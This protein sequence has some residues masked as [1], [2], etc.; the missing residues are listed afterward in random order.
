MNI[1]ERLWQ[2]IALVAGVFAFVICILLIVTYLQIKKADPINMKVISTLVERLNQNP[3]DIELRNEVR[4]LDLLSRKAYFTNQWQIR[5]GGYMLLI[6]IAIMVIALQ[7]VSLN[8]KK[9]I[10]LLTNNNGSSDLYQKTTQKWVII[11]G[12]AIIAVALFFAFLSHNELKNKFSD[13]SI[14]KTEKLDN[15]LNNIVTDTT[16]ITNSQSDT[17]VSKIDK[18]NTDSAIATKVVESTDNF[19]T[20]RG[21]GGYG[22]ANQRN[23]PTKWNGKTGDNIL[24][25]IAVPLAGFN[26]PVTWGDK[27]FI[28][29]ANTSKR[30]VYCIDKNSG[31]YLWTTVVEKV[32][33]ASAKIPKVIAET[34]FA[35]PTAATNGKAVFAIFANGDIAAIDMNGKLLWSKNLGDPQN[36]YGYSSSLMIYNDLVIVQYDQRNAPKLLALSASTGNVVWSTSRK[37]KISWASPIVVNTGKRTEIIVV[38]EPY[39]ASYNPANGEE[40]WKIDCISGEVGPS[41]AYANETVFSVNDYSKLAAIKLGETPQQVWE[42][43]EYLSD[44]PSPVATDKFVFLATSYGTVVCYDSQNGE[45]FW[46]K[47]FSNGIYASPMIADGKVYIIDRTGLTHVF[48]VD[49]EYISLGENVLG[50]N[51]VCTPAFSNGRIYLRGDKNLYCIGK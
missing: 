6:S 10:I 23:T 46:E 25:K 30:E 32:T 42:N 27:L 48:K 8:K 22:I 15:E 29:G 40:L 20:F 26:S 5:T 50:E 33:E 13:A 12:L 16:S 11:S 51:S 21:K 28:T 19:P 17:L 31:K 47:E 24:W 4:T 44:V 7:V 36:H 43:N 49:K 34:G 37:V 18:L 38:A 9:E 45:K 3:S 1:N 39:V 14:V 41:L 2:R 35:A